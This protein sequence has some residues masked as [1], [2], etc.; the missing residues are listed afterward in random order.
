MSALSKEKIQSCMLLA[1]VLFFFMAMTWIR[2]HIQLRTSQA[3]MKE[4]KKR[5]KSQTWSKAR[6]KVFCSSRLIGVKGSIGQS[7]FAHEDLGGNQVNKWI[8]G[9][10][11][12]NFSL[13]RNQLPAPVTLWELPC[14]SA[15]ALFS[16]GIGWERQVSSLSALSA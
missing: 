2:K 7:Q 5:E 3:K 4:K 14:F 13:Q 1:P 15:L 11:K 16:T 8:L 12:A 6:L 9:T 10:S